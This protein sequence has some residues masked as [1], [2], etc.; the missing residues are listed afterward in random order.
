MSDEDDP[1]TEAEI[2]QMREVRWPWGIDMWR[3]QTM[4]EVAGVLVSDLLEGDGPW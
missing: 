2:A 4:H 3:R 1:P